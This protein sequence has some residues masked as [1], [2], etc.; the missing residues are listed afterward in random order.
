MI[1]GRVSLNGV[2]LRPMV[3]LP[4]CVENGPRV[5]IE[6]TVDTGFTGYLTLSQ[7][8]VEF[9]GLEPVSD[10]IM[11]LADG[12]RAM[13]LVYRAVVEWFDTLRL[14]DVHR[15]EGNALVGMAMLQN[16]DLHVRAI[17]D[18]DVSIAP[19]DQ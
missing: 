1:T 17:Q 3:E 4:V 12:S 7:E 19:I 2:N 16:H 9:L 10:Q 8:M 13:F 15:A 6:A 18:G 14:I 11:T 5:P